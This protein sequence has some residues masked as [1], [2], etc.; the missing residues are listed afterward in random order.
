MN[1]AIIAFIV[2][3]IVGYLGLFLLPEL[4]IIFSIATTGAFIVHAIENKKSKWL[5]ILNITVLDY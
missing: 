4:G 1:R 3:I 2:T 5:L